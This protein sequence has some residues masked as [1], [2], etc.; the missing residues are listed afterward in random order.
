MASNIGYIKQ[1][2]G[3]TV[4]LEF[5]SDSL[6]N[7][8]NSVTIKDSASG[9]VITV[10]VS[11]HLGNNIVRCISMQSTDGLVRGMEAID[12]GKPISFPVGEQTLRHKFNWLG[13][14]LD[15]DKPLPEP[16][17]RWG[18][19]RKAPSVPDLIPA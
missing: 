11:Q 5:S 6:P 13:N 8:L 1:V 4:D 15:T 7:I 18:I 10:E 14:T 12:T 3:P 19:H 2:I 9:K 17:T 16:D